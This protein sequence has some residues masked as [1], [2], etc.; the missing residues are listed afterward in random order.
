MHQPVVHLSALE[1]FLEQSFAPA[2]GFYAFRGV[3]NSAFTLLPSVGRWTGR[4]DLRTDFEQSLFEDFK[5]KAVSYLDRIPTND[6]EW[7]FIAQHHGIP[8]RLLDWST[9]PLVA[10]Y[11]ALGDGQ[12]TDYAVYRHAATKLVSASMLIEGRVRPFDIG[13]DIFQVHPSYVSPRVERQ[14]SVFTAHGNPWVPLEPHGDEVTKF[15]FPTES[16]R[17]NKVKLQQLGVT[18]SL[19]F[20][21]LDGLAAEI[22]MANEMRFHYRQ[23]TIPAF[24]RTRRPDDA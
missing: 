21:G 1:E 16:R 14:G 17:A 9:S 6:W 8:T 13:S 5:R 4:E 24:P 3:T 10:L 18:G 7:L 19:L 15:V 11:F 2:E 20:P 22:R 12:N 23:E